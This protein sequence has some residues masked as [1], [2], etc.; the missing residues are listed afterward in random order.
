VGGIDR[1]GSY[2]FNKIDNKNYVYEYRVE[3]NSQWK[4]ALPIFV[5]QIHQACVRSASG[6]ADLVIQVSNSPFPVAYSVRNTKNTHDG[7]VSAF[8]FSIAV[9]F[10]PAGIITMIV[11]ERIEL[12]KH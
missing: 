12:V 7:I 5:N 4:N 8:I 6:N 9:S 3:V 2:Y 11:R 10:I 1:K